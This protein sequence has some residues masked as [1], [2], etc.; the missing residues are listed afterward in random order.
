M[1]VRTR[2]YQIVA[3]IIAIVCLDGCFG[4]FYSELLTTFKAADKGEY[5]VKFHDYEI[6]IVGQTWEKGSKQDPDTF[7]FYPDIYSTVE[8]RNRSDMDT[9]DVV[10][11]DS[12]YIYFF[13]GDSKECIFDAGHKS[14]ELYYDENKLFQSTIQLSITF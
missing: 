12:F 7:F 2:I 4:P 10:T 13:E 6:K 11:I 3:I 1:S 5:S 8:Y 9:I 14:Y